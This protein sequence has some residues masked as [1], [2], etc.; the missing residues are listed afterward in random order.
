MVTFDR[1]AAA[2]RTLAGKVRRTPCLTDDNVNLLCGNTVFCKMENLQITGAFK[3]RGVLCKIAS[4]SAAEKERGLVCATSGNHGIGV[5]YCARREGIPATIVVPEVTPVVKLELLRE[6]AQVEIA[7][8]TYQ[9]SYRYAQEKAVREGG[10]FVP[11]Y[12]DPLIIAGQATVACEIIE[13]VPDADVFVAPIGGGG[14]IAGTLIAVRN[15]R[16]GARVIGVQAAGAPSMFACWKSGT[17]GDLPEIHTIAEG[18]AVQRPGNLPFEIVREL[19]DD[20]VLVDDDDIRRGMQVLFQKFRTVAEAAGAAALAA[21]LSG[22]ISCR[23]RTIACVV[24]GGNVA[25]DQFCSV[26]GAA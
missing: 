13:D 10:T 25:P 16:P 5:G 8:K 21:V 14:L 15:L 22:R 26:T 17:I 12:D 6:Y 1:I 23:D 7:G 9:E 19:I 11:G 24:S 20:I 4:L 3:V 2:R 18:I